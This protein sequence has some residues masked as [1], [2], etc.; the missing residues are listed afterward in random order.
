MSLTNCLNPL[1]NYNGDTTDLYLAALGETYDVNI[2]VFQSNQEK[3]WILNLSNMENP[4]PETSYFARTLLL[5]VVPVIPSQKKEINV[6]VFTRKFL[7]KVS[8]CIF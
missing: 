6:S 4:Y 7:F 2:V 3:F 8:K 5:H 1:S